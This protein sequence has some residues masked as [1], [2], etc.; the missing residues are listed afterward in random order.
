VKGYFGALGLLACCFAALSCSGTDRAPGGRGPIDNVLL[1]SIDTLRADRLGCYG[2]ARPT[3]PA[4]DALA[5]EGVV[6]RHAVSPVPLTLPAHASMLTGANPPRHGVRGNAAY[7]LG[8]DNVT[9]A[10]ILADNGLA[11]GAVISA[12]VVDSRFG[13][14]QGFEDYDD[15][16]DEPVTTNVIVERN[17][18]ETTRHA[19]RWIEE[20]RQE[21]FFLFLHYFDPH[22]LHD[23]PEPYA[24]QFFDD[25]Y[26]GEIAYVDEGVGEVLD[27]LKRL[28]LFERTLVVVTADHGEMLGEHGEL[29]H[30]WFVYESA[31][32]VPLIFRAPGIGPGTRDDPVG[33][34]DIVPTICALLGLPCPDGVDGV[35]LAPLLRG[36]GGLAGRELY[37]ESL[38]PTKYGCNPLLALVGERRK[39]IETTRPEMYDLDDDPQ[40]SRNLLEL[41]PERGAA[42]RERL[43]A[44]LAE[45]GRGR[46]DAS[47]PLDEES[48]RRIEA[49]GYVAAPG[50]TE[51]LL[52]PGRDDPK[53]LIDFHS[54][55]LTIPELI[56]RGELDEA[57]RR[58]E[59]L[60]VERP[61]FADGYLLLAR[62]ARDER[63][64]EDA[65]RRYEQALEAGAR[66]ADVLGDLGSVLASVG[67]TD[68]AM[69]RYREA[70]EIDPGHVE[71]HNNMGNALLAEG[72]VVEA[73][74]HY[75]RALESRP[76]SA[77]THLN[78][79]I[80]YLRLG[81]IGTAIDH[82]S[83]S[84][85]MRPDARAEHLLGRALLLKGL[86]APAL[87]AFSRA[88]ELDPT[89]P[90]PVNDALW[91]LSAHPDAAVRDPERAVLLAEGTVDLAD[92]DDVGTLEARASAY[93]S[94]GR[95]GEAVRLARSAVDAA[96]AAGRPVEP[97][98]RRLALYEEG[99]PFVASDAGRGL[100][101]Y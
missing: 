31:I 34:I 66:R 77:A 90:P 18:G 64:P 95:Y 3:T 97:I 30:G 98:R 40:E 9:L 94:A 13:L 59:L 93:A 57:R 36:E 100:L 71:S 72:R 14:D 44:L 80:A 69:A 45:Q 28:D 83:R 62:I 82:L 37:C 42:P 10:E 39:Y 78:A 53:D 101:P 11:T 49:L 8:P 56:A 52:E 38:E 67:R 60:V 61:G 84:V 20:N 63:R 25:L 76:D 16:F 12:F 4:I 79:A 92:A 85:A 24:S 54:W 50:Q 73:L 26:D 15:V 29:S 6:F 43:A 87:E 27:A 86:A 91:L 51:A 17:A 35:N 68:E 99:L 23:P 96:T 88:H 48:R 65:I 21:R 2:Y 74:P 58:G 41:E 46:S 47:V 5:A 89:W 55:A 7:R 19:L 81:R 22:L 75:E 70:L 1:I 32:R 33:L